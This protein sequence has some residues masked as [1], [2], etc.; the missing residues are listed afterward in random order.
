[1][2]DTGPLVLDLFLIQVDRVEKKLS[3]QS[4]NRQEESVLPRSFGQ[5]E[6]YDR[7]KVLLD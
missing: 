7:P 3:Q 1:M 4:W 6:R 5:G 2:E